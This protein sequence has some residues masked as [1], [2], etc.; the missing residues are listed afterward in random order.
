ME[1]EQPAVLVQLIVTKITQM[2]VDDEAAVCVDVDTMG[3]E[4]VLRLH[5]APNDVGMVIGKQGRTARALRI[6]IGAIGVA[7]GL[8]YSLDIGSR[9]ATDQRTSIRS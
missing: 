7:H 8:R 1:N 2:I 9:S 3:T 4:T 5:V 6:I